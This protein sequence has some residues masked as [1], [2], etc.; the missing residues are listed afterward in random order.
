MKYFDKETVVFHKGKFIKAENAVTDLY[1]Q[2]LH[3]GN[4]I[5]DAMRAYDTPLGAHVFKAREH[6]TRFLESAKRMHL[7]VHYTVDELI[8]ITYTLLEKNNL[9]NAYIRPLLY[10][11]ANMELTPAGEGNL[12]IAT[13]EWEKY[14]GKDLLD[15]EI[16]T[17]TR[18]SPKSGDVEAKISG[19]YTNGIVA[20]ATA[21][22]NGFDDA[23]L[24]DVEG[25]LAEGTGANFFFEVDGKLYTPQKGHIF[26]GI[27]REVVM[28]ICQDH[29]IEV[30]EGKFKPADLSNIDGAF[31]TGTAAQITGIRSIHRRNM[32]KPWKATLGYLIAEQ[33]GHKVAQNEYDTYSII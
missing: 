10:S 25:F 19:N 33:Y 13:W 17:Y 29:G 20:A 5:F 6:Y 11:G 9:S 8:S 23:L 21:K 1:T 4:G 14:L 22:E 12:F 15:I 7:P 27:T 24:L 28:E 3:Y 30:I 32:N 16:S 18:P 2:S 31:F 26:P